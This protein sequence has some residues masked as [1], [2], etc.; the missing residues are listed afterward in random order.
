MGIF[1]KPWF[2]AFKNGNHGD[3][4]KK[5]HDEDI[6]YLPGMSKLLAGLCSSWV[7]RFEKGYEALYGIGG[8]STLLNGEG[9]GG[10]GL[11]Y[12]LCLGTST[13]GKT[14]KR[15]WEIFIGF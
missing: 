4:F 6:L 8:S 14:M 15:E 10:A 13:G 12:S 9:N 11:G 5:I 1:A 3:I 2:Y 7:G